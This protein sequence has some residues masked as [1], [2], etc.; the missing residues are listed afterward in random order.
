MDLRRN[1]ATADQILSHLRAADDAFVPT[2]STRVDLTAYS[3]KIEARAER[4]EMWHGRQLAGLVAMYC[5]DTD[6]G[7]A[8]VTSVSVL[9]EHAGRGV[10]T[11][12][13]QAAIELAQAGGMKSMRLEVGAQNAAALKLYARLGFLPIGGPDPLVLELRLAPPESLK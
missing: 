7:A 4:L 5:N 2:L 10:A 8:F 6:S 13:M 12:L 1:T 9:Q 11:E 3:T